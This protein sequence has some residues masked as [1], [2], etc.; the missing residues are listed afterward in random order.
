MYLLMFS[1]RRY[2]VNTLLKIKPKKP[3]PAS[4]GGKNNKNHQFARQHS[5]VAARKKRLFCSS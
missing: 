2:S 5:T 4:I 3:K 1:K